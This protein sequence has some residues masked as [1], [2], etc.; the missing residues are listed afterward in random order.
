MMQNKECEVP[1]PLNIPTTPTSTYET[2]LYDVEIQGKSFWH[3]DSKK[4][5][6]KSYVSD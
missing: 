3:S 1:V 6:K 2:R 5:H 4:K